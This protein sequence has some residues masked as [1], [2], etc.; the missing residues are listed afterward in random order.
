MASDPAHSRFT[1]D[2]VL[3]GSPAHAFRF[4]SDPKLKNLWAGCHPDWTEREVRHDFRVGGHDFSRLA[5]PA[6][7]EHEVDI[8]YLDIAAPDRV[9]YS[10]AMRVNAKPL[11]ASLVTLLFR[12][13]NR[14]S[15][16]R[17]DEHLL[18]LDGSEGATAR[19]I[20]TGHG[21]DRLE[22]VMA[23]HLAATS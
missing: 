19:E 3:P 7:V 13:H 17:Y 8:A 14:G 22:A 18:L 9:V 21:F 6:G 15:L 12:P 4:W 1:L 20:G 2:R 11:S 5:D 16:M 23:E 10:Y